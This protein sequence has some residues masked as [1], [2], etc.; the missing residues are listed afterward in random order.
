MQGHIRKRSG[1]SWEVTIN[2]GRDAVTGKR[3]QL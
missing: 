2:L 3:R 1:S